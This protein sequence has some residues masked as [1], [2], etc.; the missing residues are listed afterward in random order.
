[1]SL[2]HTDDSRTSEVFTAP[3][4]PRPDFQSLAHKEKASDIYFVLLVWA[5]VLVQIWLNL[6][7]LQLL[8]IPFAGNLG[9]SVCMLAGQ[10]VYTCTHFSLYWCVCVCVSVTVWVI[11]RLVVHFGVKNFAQRTLA[12]WWVV[13]ERFIRDRQDALLPGPIKGLSQFLLRVDTKVTLQ[14]QHATC[15]D[16]CTTLKFSNDGGHYEEIKFRCLFSSTVRVNQ[17]RV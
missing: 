11:K 12:A 1:M 3:L 7:I 10:S 2:S 5:I 6:W 15:H 14:T 4:R 9:V 8:P 17:L 13:L 16:T